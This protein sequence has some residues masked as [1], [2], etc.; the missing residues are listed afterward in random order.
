MQYQVLIDSNLLDS[1]T[2]YQSDILDCLII[3]NFAQDDKIA[4]TVNNYTRLTAWILQEKLTD[5]AKF[6]AMRAFN[7]LYAVIS[8]LAK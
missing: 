6:E 5:T 1:F 8:K 3:E 7:P 4:V 2:E